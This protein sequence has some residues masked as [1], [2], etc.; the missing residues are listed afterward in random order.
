MF[1]LKKT[2]SIVMLISL[3]S[4]TTLPLNGYCE[5]WVYGGSNKYWYS[6]LQFIIS[7]NR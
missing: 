1:M 4:L 7:K 5:D 6:V 3:V 2:I